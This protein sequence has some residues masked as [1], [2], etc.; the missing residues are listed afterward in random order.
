MF[1]FAD[2][3]QKK[4]VVQATST[5]PNVSVEIAQ[6]KAIPG[7]AVITLT[8]KVTTDKV[9]YVVNFG[10]KSSNDE[11]E[12]TVGSQWSWV[13]E[14]KSKIDFKKVP[15]S[16]TITSAKGDIV[17][18]ENIQENILVQKAN[19]DW[20]AETK[21]IY[22]R[23]PSGHESAG[24]IAYQDDDNYVKLGYGFNSGSI[25]FLA[26]VSEVL[27]LV[28]ETKG[29]QYWAFTIDADDIVKA[30]NTVFLK[31]E[32]K[33]SIFTGYYSTDGKNFTKLGS[34]EA[35]LTDVKAGLNVCDGVK[36]KLAMVVPLLSA[37]VRKQDRNR[38]QVSYDYFHIT[39]AGLK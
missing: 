36:D 21:M 39:N 32:K 12:G 38:L 1:L 5:N 14:N 30:D 28:I 16:L 13:R 8:D 6:A 17:N 29:S 27:E 34:A 26:P 37:K 10:I 23:R 11:F 15:G 9:E 3:S 33:G 31:L 4:P 18:D 2:G 22:S 19:T 20:S 25:G 24:I 7:D 35:V